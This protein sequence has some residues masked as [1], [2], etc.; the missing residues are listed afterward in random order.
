MTV[1]LLMGNSKAQTILQGP[2]KSKASCTS[3]TGSLMLPVAIDTVHGRQVLNNDLAWEN[4]DVILVKFM[5]NIGSQSLRNLIMQYAKEW[6]QYANIKF[7]FVPDNT[8]QTNMR[9]KLGSMFDSL[10]HNS[11][12]G[13]SCSEIPQHMQTINLDSSD[14]IDY[15]SYEDEIKN[16]GPVLQY[17]RNKGVDF[18]NYTY[19]DFYKDIIAYPDPNKKW[20][21]K[22]MRGTTM[23]EF[24]HS[25]GLLHE[26]SYPGG[27]KWNTDTVYNY[28]AKYQGWDKEK[29]DFNVLKASDVFYTNG[30]SYDPLSIMHYPVESWQTQDGFSVA[31][32]Y[33]LSEGDKKIVAAMYPK[34]QK[35]SSLAVPKIEIS[36]VTTV[37][38][39]NDN[40]KKGI[41][42]YPSFDIKTSAVLGKVYFVARLVTAD[43]QNYIP[44]TNERYSWN[45]MAATYIKMNMLPSSSVHYNKGTVRDLEL[46]FP[47]KEMPELAGQTVKIHF[48]VYVN[49]EVNSRFSKLAFNFLSSSLNVP[50]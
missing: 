9:I 7:K 14:F 3:L 42:I 49:D 10:G 22:S 11:L 46:F 44:T 35:I 4:G 36:N 37:D 17:L 8:P 28:Y 38:V 31:P 2:P 32:T 13:I 34:N 6:E 20:V 25:L 1:L 24:G 47:F 18:K 27:I 39:K 5:N 33:D 15:K 50:K 45:K 19:A 43:G 30:S 23:H 21:Y 29:V 40:I 16:G 12:I 26:Q 41:L 48:S